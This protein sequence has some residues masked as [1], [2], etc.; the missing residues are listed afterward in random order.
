MLVS[1]VKRF[2]YVYQIMLSLGM[3]SE[4]TMLLVVVIAYANTAIPYIRAK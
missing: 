2:R 3:V 1:A 4:M